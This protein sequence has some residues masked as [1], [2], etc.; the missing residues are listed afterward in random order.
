MKNQWKNILIASITLFVKPS[1]ADENL[2]KFHKVMH[3]ASYDKPPDGRTLFCSGINR[4]D[5]WRPD[6]FIDTRTEECQIKI[7]NLNRNAIKPFLSGLEIEPPSMMRVDT[8]YFLLKLPRESCH[9]SETN[10]AIKVSKKNTQPAA[11]LEIHL[12][13]FEAGG[14]VN[15]NVEIAEVDLGLRIDAESYPHLS[16]KILPTDKETWLEFNP[17][18]LV[19]YW[20][21]IKSMTYA[22]TKAVEDFFYNG[23]AKL[24]CRNSRP[25]ASLVSDKLEFTIEKK[26]SEFEGTVFRNGI[27]IHSETYAQ[28]IRSTFDSKEQMALIQFGQPAAPSP[29]PLE[30]W[31]YHYFRQDYQLSADWPFYGLIRYSPLSLESSDAECRLE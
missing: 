7:Q 31:F 8:S 19:H 9:I 18:Y 24:R 11:H 1:F 2:N 4:A 28:N 13:S 15:S 25:K 23:K 5:H 22:Q 6:F 17:A 21:C 27:A 26:N 12:D 14:K 10:S 20:G 16:Y 29:V 3:V 30:I